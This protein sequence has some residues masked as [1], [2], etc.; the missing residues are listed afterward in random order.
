MIHEGCCFSEIVNS[1]RT[2]C[3]SQ[4]KVVYYIRKEA[5]SYG[6]NF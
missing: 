5:M 6:K 2:A 1:L 4:A 3:I